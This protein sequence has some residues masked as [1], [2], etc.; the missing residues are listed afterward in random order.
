MDYNWNDVLRRGVSMNEI[1]HKDNEVYVFTNHRNILY[2]YEQEFKITKENRIN[3]LKYL[4]KNN[5]TKWNA[6]ENG[7][8][9]VE[10]FEKYAEQHDTTT[11]KDYKRLDFFLDV[12]DFEKIMKIVEKLVMKKEDV[13][14]MVLKEFLKGEMPNE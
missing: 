11:E 2:D 5:G 9:L 7:E 10:A 13:I 1:T 14:N 4:S 3:L 6:R 12:R 8:V